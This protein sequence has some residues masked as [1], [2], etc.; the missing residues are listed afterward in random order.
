MNKI[1]F[2]FDFF[3]DLISSI[4]FPNSVSVSMMSMMI[5][6]KIHQIILGQEIRH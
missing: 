1:N 3:Q 6:S 4:D 5:T 2:L